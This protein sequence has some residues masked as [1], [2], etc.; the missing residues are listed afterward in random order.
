MCSNTRGPAMVPS[1]VTCP[2]RNTVTPLL[3]ASSRRRAAHSRTCEIEPAADSIS[4]RVMVWIES[5]ITRVGLVS[6]MC[7][8]I[9]ARLVSVTSSRRLGNLGLPLLSFSARRSARILIWRSD[10]SP[11][12]YNTVCFPASSI[13]ICSVR[14]LLPM[15]GSPPIKTTEPGTIPPPNTRA[16]SSIGSGRRSSG[17]LS[18]SESEC[19]LEEPVSPRV[20]R[21]DFSGSAST[22]SSIIE[23]QLS[24]PGQRPKA[25]ELT[26]PQT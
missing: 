11:E 8:K 19:T 16:N 20:A 6:S 5:M 18:I 3:F 2:I 12:T 21:A 13:A 25:R 17:R 26:F 4:G 7:L 24:Q 22:I 9:C 10:S 1:L 14:V 15:P 23:S